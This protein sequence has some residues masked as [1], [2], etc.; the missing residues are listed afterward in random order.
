[1]QSKN[2]PGMAARR[3]EPGRD[4]AGEDLQAGRRVGGLVVVWK[5]GE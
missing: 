1:M 3:Q 4:D 5:G 2:D